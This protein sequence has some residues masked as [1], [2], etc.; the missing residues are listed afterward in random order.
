[1]RAE[2]SF[3]VIPTFAAS[4]SVDAFSF[5]SV[6]SIFFSISVWLFCSVVSRSFRFAYSG[7]HGAF[8]FRTPGRALS[9]FTALEARPASVVEALLLPFPRSAK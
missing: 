9:G 2:S 5:E 8:V 6:A 7:A 3:S 1:M 4:V